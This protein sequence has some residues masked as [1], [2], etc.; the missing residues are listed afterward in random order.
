MC[1]Q[2]FPFPRLSPSSVASDLP[3]LGT[4]LVSFFTG[5]WSLPSRKSQSPAQTSRNAFAF[6]A[7]P[8]SCPAGQHLTHFCL[9]LLTAKP[10][11]RR[12][13]SPS[14]RSH[15]QL[16]KADLCPDKSLGTDLPETLEVAF[17]LLSSS[18][19]SPPRRLMSSACSLQALSLWG[20]LRKHEPLT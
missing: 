13:K 7:S 14:S 10:L 5:K 17:L 15:L 2:V 19:P 6:T 16:R 4:F 18:K 11:G 20:H 8:S 3:P 9:Q 12:S 1:P